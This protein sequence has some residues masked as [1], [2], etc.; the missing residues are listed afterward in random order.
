M[1]SFLE[2]VSKIVIGLGILLVLVGFIGYGNSSSYGGVDVLATFVLIAFGA[3]VSFIG[4]IALAVMQFGRAG[5]DS[6]EYT[7][8][9]LKISRDQLDVSRQALKQGAST[10]QGFA[11]LVQDDPD[12]SPSHA[13]QAVPSDTTKEPGKPNGKAEQPE[14]SLLQKERPPAQIEAP[15]EPVLSFA[16]L[17]QDKVQVEASVPKDLPKPDPSRI[18]TFEGRDI[19]VE[20]GKYNVNGIPFGTQQQA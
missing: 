1:F 6:A 16:D 2:V 14:G 7:Q 11:D 19:V 10:P 4:L 18:I 12:T 8:Q 13:Q 9:M 15:S 5:V 17:N 3:F 20:N